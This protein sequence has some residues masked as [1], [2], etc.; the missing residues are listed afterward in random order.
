[1]VVLDPILTDVILCKGEPAPT[2]LS[3]HQIIT[4]VLDKMRPG[5]SIQ[6]GD[7]PP[8]YRLVLILKFNNPTHHL[9][10]LYTVRRMKLEPVRLNVT[11]R[12]GNKRVTLVDNLEYFDI[13]AVDIAHQVQRIAAASAT[14]II[15]FS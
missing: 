11:T 1:M 9:L 8:T 15:T 3:W 2:Q 12:T 5:Y 10:I 4:R 13:S 6:R 7:D 14:G